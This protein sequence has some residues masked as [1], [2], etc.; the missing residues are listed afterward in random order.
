MFSNHV[1]KAHPEIAAMPANAV[2]SRHVVALLRPLIE[3]GN[4]RP[5]RSCELSARL[6][7]TRRARRARQ[8]RA[9]RVPAV[10]R[11]VQSGAD[12]GALSKFTRARERALTEP[13]LRNYWQALQD[14]PDSPARDAQLLSMHLGGQRTAQLLRAL[15]G[16][17]DLTG[18]T[19]TLRD[20]KGKREQARV[21]VLPLT[22][23]ALTV[24]NRCI[25]RA[26]AQ[27]AKRGDPQHPRY[28][29]STHG[30]VALR[31]ETVTQAAATLPRRCSPNRNP[32][33][34]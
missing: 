7:R 31:P 20:K 6:L 11:R 18:R 30:R 27:H 29:F 16:D 22:D 13:E 24:V 1:A 33:A 34:S 2:T 8:R 3:A 21:H 17:V 14:S 9:G 10:R 26:D 25:T 5:R 15:T 28:L 19:I 12:I 23:A 4:G 32:S